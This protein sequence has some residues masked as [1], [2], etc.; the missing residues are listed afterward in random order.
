M[1]QLQNQMTPKIKALPSRR[2]SK[3]TAYC[4]G[5][6]S[7]SG[8]GPFPHFFCQ[9]LTE[10]R[11]PSPK[12]AGSS[13]VGPDFNVSN[14]ASVDFSAGA[15]LFPTEG[16]YTK[17]PPH[18]HVNAECAKGLF[19]APILGAV[20]KE[21]DQK[22]HIAKNESLRR[23]QWSSKSPQH[24]PSGTSKTSGRTE[25]KNACNGASLLLRLS[26]IAV[27]LTIWTYSSTACASS[28]ISRPLNITPPAIQ[29]SG[30]GEEVMPPKIPNLYA[31]IVHH[32]DSNAM[33]LDQCN[34]WHRARGWDSCGYNF[35]IQRDG[36]V[37]TARGWNKVGAHCKGF[38]RAF[39]GVCF[40]GKD[41]AT[42][43]QIRA[44]KAWFGG[45][46]FYGHKN[47]GKTL[48]PGKML[49]QIRGEK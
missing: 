4:N 41:Y 32:S 17:T 35:I 38:N 1:I 31:V 21:G 5:R 6:I 45:R 16:L 43:E 15:F 30:A 2:V 27:A 3:D 23:L 28:E 29:S 42:P 20:G 24:R 12:F 9:T 26:A 18:R 19:S 25:L 8:A 44:F 22:C 39:L 11:T 33:T 47:F 10:I 14:K 7:V 46:P 36:T 40:V 13:P 49:E 34:E 48:C 37:N